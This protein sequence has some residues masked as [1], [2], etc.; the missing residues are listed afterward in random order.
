LNP[1][2]AEQPVLA[3]SAPLTDTATLAA[4]VFRTPEGLALVGFAERDVK[5]KETW[6]HLTRQGAAIAKQPIG[7]PDTFMVVMSTVAMFPARGDLNAGYAVLTPVG[8]TSA[9]IG[10][11]T[12][13]VRNR[14]ALFE[15]SANPDGGKVTVEALNAQGKVIASVPSMAGTEVP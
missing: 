14:L 10:D 11:V 13:P 4:T 2:L 7:D 3:I 6:R 15:P 8:A 12:V 9:R 5:F 1:S